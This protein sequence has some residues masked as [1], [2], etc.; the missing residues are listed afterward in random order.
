MLSPTCTGFSNAR[1]G[2]PVGFR[3]TFVIRSGIDCF[4]SSTRFFCFFCFID[5][6]SLSKKE[7]NTDERIKINRQTKKTTARRCFF[8]FISIDPIIYGKE[9]LA[10]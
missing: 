9:A 8:V 1:A 10:S 7:L 5:D 3:V 2:T 4:L 6:F